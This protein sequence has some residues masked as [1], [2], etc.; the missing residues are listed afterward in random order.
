MK[1]IYTILVAIMLS[2]SAFAQAPDKMTYQAVVRDASSTLITSTQVGIE[3]NIYQTTASETLVY[4]ETQTPSTNVNGLL[5]I[6]IGGQTGFDQIDWAN[7][8]YFI[9][10][11][12]DVA[13][14]TN[15][16]ITGISQLLSVPYAL[17][18]K[19]A[20]S[21]GSV[22]VYTSTEIAAL[23]PAEGDAV[24]NSTEDLYQ[25]YNGSEWKAFNANCWPQPT[26]AYAGSDQTFTDGTVT[27]ILSA[28]TPESQH[29]TGAWSIVSGTGGS[30]TDETDPTTIFNGTLYNVY[31]LLW[32]ITTSCSSSINDVVIAFYQD[33][34]GSTLIDADGNTYNT[35][36]IGSQLW[37]AENL[38]VTQEAGGTAIPLVTDST[39]WENL[40]DN[41]T[42]KAYCYYSN[43]TDS[44]AKYGALYTYAAA[45]NACPTGWHLPTDAEWSELKW[46]ISNDGHGGAE[47]TALR[48]TNG[49]LYGGNGTDDYDFSGLPGGYRSDYLVHFG[50]VGNNGMWWSATEND[51]Y[52]AYDR[53]LERNYAGVYR[54]SKSK[55]FGLSV[56]CVRD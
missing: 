22:S 40:D 41:D 33:G 51:S 24:F 16:S 12:I 54:M 9:E 5:S 19:T 29:G 36:Y 2:A 45:K 8:S 7:G 21:S 55:S 15:Y 27:A 31:T 14:G 20:E 11:N 4:T 34:A 10:T 38:K 52:S 37:M 6:E 18:A 42:D 30:F 43:S 49:W 53:I 25:I 39:A 47:G 46:Y 13:G 17:R 23:T 44:L 32:T 3:I 28:N 35:V 56:R 1:R 26:T 50:N 48:S